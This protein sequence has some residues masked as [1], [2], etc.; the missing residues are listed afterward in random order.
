MLYE[1]SAHK[2]GSTK[3]H[4]QEPGR[5]QTFV[6]CME[7]IIPPLLRDPRLQVTE[8][9]VLKKSRRQV[10][11]DVLQVRQQ[12]IGENDMSDGNEDRRPNTLSEK[13]YSGSEVDICGIESGLDCCLRALKADTSGETH[14]T[15][16]RVDLRQF[17]VK[18]V[19]RQSDRRQWA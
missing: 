2:C 18:V 10:G 9:I 4:G 6:D 15:R 12:L 17:R 3:G 7:D 14:E 5:S 19:R 16:E 11:H 13:N 1:K 8:S